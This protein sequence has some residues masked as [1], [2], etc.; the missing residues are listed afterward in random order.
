MGLD[1]SPI[2]FLGRFMK[3]WEVNTGK[4]PLVDSLHRG[5]VIDCHVPQIRQIEA[6]EAQQAASVQAAAE[7]C[8]YVECHWEIDYSYDDYSREDEEGNEKYFAAISPRDV[9][10]DGDTPIGLCIEE[11]NQTSTFSSCFDVTAKCMYFP[12]GTASIYRKDGVGRYQ[13]YRLTLRRRDEVNMPLQSD[14]YW[15]R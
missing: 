4:R 14:F 15:K 7:W 6:N 5:G 1:S 11:R 12:D 3:I 10:F 2:A 8:L 13:T 9:L